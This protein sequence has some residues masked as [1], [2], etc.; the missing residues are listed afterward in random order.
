M[1]EVTVPGSMWDGISHLP[2]CTGSP[3]T[4]PG[5]G[6]RPP[7]EMSVNP[8]LVPSL[9]AIRVS[10]VF[11]APR[12]LCFGDWVSAVPVFNRQMFATF[13][14]IFPLQMYLSLSGALM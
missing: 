6:M 13:R 11:N 8:P 1:F 12:L 2:H 5:C 4:E 14:S 9:P 3:S 7:G 10:C